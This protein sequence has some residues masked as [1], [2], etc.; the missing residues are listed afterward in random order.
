MSDGPGLVRS[1]YER[2]LSGADWPLLDTIVADDFVEHELVPGVPPTREGLKQKYD[3]L[4]TGFADLAFRVEDLVVSG[5]RVAAR[6]GVSGTHTGPML[7]REP[8]GRTF[9]VTS[10]GIFRLA[11]GRIAEHWGVFDQIGMLMQLGAFP[12]QG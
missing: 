8:S 6:V 10:V 12:R 5:D 4:H 2:A 3:L 11:D 1:Y 7:G 9:A